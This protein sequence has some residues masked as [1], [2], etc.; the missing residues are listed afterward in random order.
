MKF[1]EN[2]RPETLE[3]KYLGKLSK[4]ALSFMKACLKLN[5]AER[6]TAAE[7]LKHPY[8][9]DLR[10]ED[11]RKVNIIEREIDTARALSVNRANQNTRSNNNIALQSQKSIVHEIEKPPLLAYDTKYY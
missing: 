2:I 1:P 4:K 5:P 9:E 8:F 10:E 3:K 11:L 6:I 7:A